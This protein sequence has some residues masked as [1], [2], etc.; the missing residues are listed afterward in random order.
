MISYYLEVIILSVIQGVTEFIPVSSSAHLIVISN[1]SNFNLNS[2]EVD[3]S[4]HLGSLLAIVVYFWRDLINF[5]KNRKKLYLIFFGSMP[6]IIVGYALYI[7]NLIY[8]LRNLELIAWTTLIFG[9]LL[10][11]SDKN[12]T[13]KVLEKDLSKKDIIFIGMLQIL[14][15]IPGVS[16]S[17][18]NITAGRL[19]RYNRVDSA[20]ISFFLSIPALAGASLLGLKDILKDPFEFN[21][22]IYL[23]ISIS[24][25]FSYLT[26]KF[27]LYYLNKFS[28]KIFVFYRIILAFFLFTVIYF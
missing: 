20:K 24:F 10:Y 13:D 28:L 6:L 22:I 25:I 21:S 1:I 12:K 19:V 18:I 11:F 27:L 16:R 7:S 26:I 2:L 4:L 8:H 9:V 3:V 15:L 14:S 17:G 23:T 5:S